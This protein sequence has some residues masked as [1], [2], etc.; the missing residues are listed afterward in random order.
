MIA[1]KNILVPTDFSETSEIAVTYAKNL[2]EAFGATVHLLHV[3]QDPA[4]YLPTEAL[5]AL[6]NLGQQQ[7][8]AARQRLAKLLGESDANILDVKRVVLTGTPF[9]DIIRYAKQHVIDLIVMGT[10]G[11][12]PVKHILLGSVAEKIVRKAPCPVLTVRPPAHQFVMP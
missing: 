5:A 8:L 4:S 6:P 3:L 10:H 12:G 7:E 11:R 2:A 1:L 9:V